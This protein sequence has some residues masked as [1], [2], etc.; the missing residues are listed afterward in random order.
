[1]KL[2]SEDIRKARLLLILKTIQQHVKETEEQENL[3][4]KI[5]TITELTGNEAVKLSYLK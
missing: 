2:L 3:Y 4:K 1:M 5:K